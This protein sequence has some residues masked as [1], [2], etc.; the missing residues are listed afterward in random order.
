MSACEDRDRL[1]HEWQKSVAGFSD[2]V[3]RLR[4]CNGDG[5]GFAE[6]YEA[7]KQARWNA[8]EVL[9]L[10]ELHRDEHGC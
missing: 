10:L 4:D 5:S 1:L 9:K 3:R 2:A 8:E 7:T 6:E